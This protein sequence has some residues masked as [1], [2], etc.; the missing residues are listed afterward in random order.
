MIDVRAVFQQGHRDL[1]VERLPPVLLPR[2]G[3]FGLIDYE[4]VFC[5]DPAAGDIFDLRGVDREPAAWSSSARTSTSP[6]VLPLD[7][8]DE[9]TAFPRP[10]TLNEGGRHARQPDRG[11]APRGEGNRVDA[12]STEQTVLAGT[13]AP[14]RVAVRPLQFGLQTGRS[15][16][17]AISS[18]LPV[19]GEF[20]DSFGEEGTIVGLPDTRIQLE[21]VRARGAVAAADPLDML[22]FYLSGAAAVDDGHRAPAC[23]RG[24]EGSDPHPYWVARG[25]VVHLD[26]DGRRVV[27]APWIY[28]DEPKPGNPPG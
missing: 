15:P 21:I 22:V 10:G 1:A 8:H 12:G 3:R 6:H 7:G 18:G 11:T 2:K 28:G 23:S 16:T 14:G 24:A 13:S 9:L 17:T 5:P 25:G 20:A 27:F 4:K 26:P 19:V